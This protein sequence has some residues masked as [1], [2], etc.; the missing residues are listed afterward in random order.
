MIGCKL[1]TISF[2]N[3]INYFYNLYNYFHN[4]YCLLPFHGIEFSCQK[5]IGILRPSNT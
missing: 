1:T 3:S 4:C 5:V 2:H